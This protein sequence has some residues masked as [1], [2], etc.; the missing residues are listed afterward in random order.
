MMQRGMCE[1]GRP[2]AELGFYYRRRVEGGAGL[3]IGERV[4]HA[5]AAQLGAGA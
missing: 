5:Y 3:I 4:E 2:S 1:Q